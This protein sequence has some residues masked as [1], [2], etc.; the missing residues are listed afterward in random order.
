MHRSQPWCIPI[1]GRGGIGMKIIEAIVQSSKVNAVKGALVKM[2]VRGLTVVN[3]NGFGNNKAERE[4]YRGAEFTP[5]FVPMM[6]IRVIVGDDEAQ[7]A[8]DN[9]VHSTQTG[10]AGDGIIFESGISQLVRISTGEKGE[11][12]L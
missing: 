10:K 4:I 12:A 9:I 11:K 8:V 6:N 2:G 1:L 7:R 5:E 3:V